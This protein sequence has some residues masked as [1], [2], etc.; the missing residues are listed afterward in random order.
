MRVKQPLPAK[1]A[2]GNSP[3]DKPWERIA[4]DVM[5]VQINSKGNRCI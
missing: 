5:E 2:L 1:F 3:I 4:V